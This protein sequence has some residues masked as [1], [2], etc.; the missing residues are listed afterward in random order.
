MPELEDSSGLRLGSRA[1]GRRVYMPIGERSVSIGGFELPSVPASVNLVDLGENELPY[2]L[3]GNQ[4][5]RDYVL[6]I[7]Y[8]GGKL[9][10][11]TP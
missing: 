11:E 4:V 2:A 9:Y 6:T 3:L 8:R 1:A 7:D 10:F 5:L